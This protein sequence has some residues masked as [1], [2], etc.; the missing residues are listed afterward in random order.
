MALPWLC[1]HDVSEP[2]AARIESRLRK[3]GAKFE[4]RVDAPV[5][6]VGLLLTKDAERTRIESIC[7]NCARVDGHVL[8]LAVT[9]SDPSVATLAALHRSGVGDV[10][11]WRDDTTTPAAIAA[12][13]ARWLQVE[14]I[15]ASEVDERRLCAKSR[16]LR[17]VLRELIEVAVFTTDPV[18]IL[19]ESGTGKEELARLVHRVD[20]RG[21]KRDFVVL[22]CTTVPPELAASEFFG[23]ERGAFTSALSPRDGALALADGGTLFLDEVGELPPSMQAQLLRAVQEKTFKRVGGSAWHKSEFR[24]VCA[25]H[26]KIDDPHEQ[27]FRR[28]FFHRIARWVFRVPGLAERPEDIVPLAEHFAAERLGKCPGFEDLLCA[29]LNAREYPGNARDLRNLVTRLCGRHVGDGPM[30]LGDLAPQDLGFQNSQVPRLEA[31]VRTAI[32]AGGE[33]KDVQRVVRSA[34][35]DAALAAH[36][37]SVGRAARMLGFSDRALQMELA[38]RFEAAAT[39]NGSGSG[40]DYRRGSDPPGRA[41]VEEA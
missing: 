13:L 24:L 30:A 26:R 6:G 28:D 3:A 7:A 41:G 40:A 38:K 21:G 34:A 9:G 35:I 2:D 32:L 33:L 1:V 8:V 31:A 37:G 23:H 12:R 27:S 22:D 25:T 39:S 16:S 14:E 10:R 17:T 11:S 4:R 20:R 5:D 15:L 29:C 19:G 36:D 18:L